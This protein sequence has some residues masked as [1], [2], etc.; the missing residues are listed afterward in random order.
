MTQKFQ[1]ACELSKSKRYEEAIDLLNEILHV[2]SQDANAI[3][4]RGVCF[5]H[6]NNKDASLKDMDLAVRLQ[7]SKSYRYSSRAY[8]RNHFGDLMGGIDDYR[9][10]IELDPEDAIAHNNLGLLEEQLGY[11]EHSKKRFELADL[12]QSRNENGI[13]TQ[14]IDEINASARN[15]QQEIKLEKLE[16]DDKT[17]LQVLL[18]IFSKEGF[19]SFVKF[20]KSGFKKV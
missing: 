1:Q 8:I 6:L 5:M 13:P 3:S 4:E 2:N 17:F 14:T 20:I 12:L 18:S 19:K 7:P 11:K 10:A 16:K 9:K 15:I